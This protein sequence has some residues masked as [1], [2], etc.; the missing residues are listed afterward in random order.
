LIS[1]ILELVSEDKNLAEHLSPE[2]PY[3]KAE[4]IYAVT[5]EG[6]QSV[7]DVLARRTRIAFEANDGGDSLSLPVATLIAPILGWDMEAK[8]KSAAEF[9]KNLKGE[10]A[11]L[12][13]MLTKV[14]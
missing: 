12:S 2:L 10:R 14:R 6:A 9:S 4:V 13:K 7:E 11:A 5:H 3:I 8:K 1:E